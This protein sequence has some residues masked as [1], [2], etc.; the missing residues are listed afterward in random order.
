M[1][2]IHQ[3]CHLT[4]M[5]SGDRISRHTTLAKWNIVQ[6]VKADVLCRKLGSGAPVRALQSR[7]DDN[8]GILAEEPDMWRV[9]S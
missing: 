8:T 1:S 6:E 7:P 4:Y 5:D 3:G 9:S 2:V